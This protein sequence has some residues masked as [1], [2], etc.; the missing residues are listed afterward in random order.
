MAGASFA[1][2]SRSLPSSLT[3]RG[4]PKQRV[5]ISGEHRLPVCSSWQR[6]KTAGFKQRPG[7]QRCCRQ[8]AVNYRLAAYAP[9]NTRSHA[10]RIV[11]VCKR[12]ARKS[13]DHPPAQSAVGIDA[14]VTQK[15]PMRPMLVYPAPFHIGDHNLFFV[16][17]TFC[18]DLAVRSANKTLPPK[19]DSVPSGRRFLAAPIRRSDIAAIRDRMAALDRFPRGML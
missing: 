5:S 16:D 10:F 1:K 11:I 12:P 17:G 8:A 3:Q 14:A 13:V 9:R 2:P 6:A 15:W 19:F 18:N 7:V 4:N